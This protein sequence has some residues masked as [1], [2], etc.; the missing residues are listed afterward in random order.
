MACD[1]SDDLLRLEALS[2]ADRAE[3]L[4]HAS[5]CP[6]C[7]RTRALLDGTRSI[8]TASRR[9][10]APAGRVALR[11]GL[12]RRLEQ[13]S[14]APWIVGLAAAAAAIAAIVLVRPEPAPP[15]PAI[16]LAAPD[17]EPMPMAVKKGSEIVID[18]GR[19]TALEDASLAVVRS[20]ELV[21]LDLEA[22]ALLL[23]LGPGAAF[24]VSTP[25]ARVRAS[26]STLRVI[27]SR[28]ETRVEVE[29][30][31]ASMVGEDGVSRR[32]LSGERASMPP[33]EVAVIDAPRAPERLIAPVVRPALPRR[34]PRTAA[35]KAAAPKIVA[36]ELA[37]PVAEAIET[38]PAIPDPFD[39]PKV[40]VPKDDTAKVEVEAPAVAPP[41][42]ESDLERMRRADALR[43][44]GDL[45]EALGVYAG[46]DA[47]SPF[48]EE[49]RYLEAQ[50]LKRQD[51]TAEAIQALERAPARKLLPERSAL[52]A[53]LLASEDRHA[54]ALD[55]LDAVKT[56]GL[57]IRSTRL[58]IGR[59]ALSSDARLARR[60][61]QPLLS[62]PNLGI[63][64][65]ALHIA[66][67]AAHD[68]RDEAEEEALRATLE[69]IR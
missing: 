65:R 63:R 6:D 5:A 29:R 60:A 39:G 62:S 19:I 37:P 51:R 32:V 17:A 59:S 58:A 45:D 42:V 8:L 61:I 2:D 20:P 23:E 44:G 67:E 26:D 27:A 34:A 28:V 18:S 57:E 31:E 36:P 9:E 54:E 49:A 40:D 22:G 33:R 46:I 14:R 55:A 56:D 21:E 48:A 35:P 53:Q 47:G 38:T 24:A 30:G 10:L 13:R 50:I 3:V 52:L 1:R 69:K 43:R 41:I 66:I 7:R 12:D 68:L 11:E 4:A 25:T 64:V 15:P 16:V